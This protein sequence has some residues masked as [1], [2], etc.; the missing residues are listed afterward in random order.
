MAWYSLILW[1]VAWHGKCHQILESYA[2]AVGRE[3]DVVVVKAHTKNKQYENITLLFLDV[4]FISFG[5]GGCHRDGRIPPKWWVKNRWSVGMI[6]VTLDRHHTMRKPISQVHTTRF[7][8]WNK[9][10]SQA[11]STYSFEV[12]CCCSIFGGCNPSDGWWYSILLLLCWFFPKS[13]V[14]P[15]RILFRGEEGSIGWILTSYDGFCS[16][17]V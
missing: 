10:T 17:E 16:P 4:L 2:W 11:T 8:G 9:T 5:F 12:V 15:G 3:K 1:W 13:S 6:G 14:I 7:Q